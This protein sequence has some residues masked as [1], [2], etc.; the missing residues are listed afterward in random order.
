MLIDEFLYKIGFDVDSAKLQRVTVALNEIK[1]KAQNLNPILKN[2]QLIQGLDDFNNKVKTE[3]GEI[4][5]SLNEAANKATA[6]GEAIEKTAKS[7]DKATK[8]SKSLKQQFEDIKN[9]F[10]LVGIG[11]SVLGGLV[12][13]FLS[14]PLANIDKLALEKNKLF[15]ITSAEIDQAKEYHEKLKVTKNYFSSIATQVALKLLPSVNQGTAGF[16][17]FL[18]A[19][20]GLVVDGLT[21]VFE[22]VLKISQVF[23]NSFRA[24]NI[25]I[26][27]TI[28]WKNALIGLVGILAIVKRATILA[29]AF[30]PIG[31]LIGAITLLMLAY[32]D[33]MVYLD[34][35]KSFF[36]EL[37]DP[38][39]KGCETAVEWINYLKK[40]F[41]E[42]IE[43]FKN[44]NLLDTL[45]ETWDA[46]TKATK[47]FFGFGDAPKVAVQGVSA[48]GNKTIYNQG[49]TAQTTIN[50]NTNNENLANSVINNRQK[51]DL[52]FTN[53][54]FYG[55]D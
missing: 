41:N 29:F 4:K 51:S 23:M 11:A 38:F 31:L 52:A 10:F 46:T 35:G 20:K 40:T 53:S 27:S 14:V 32:D 28:G 21:K 30:S 36:G 13:K 33:L 22:W 1:A 9:K 39:I 15:D 26:T 54:N 47:M 7:I 37:W 50:I 18:K 6:S 25:M 48:Q 43:K 16:N 55:G 49:G 44:F 19:N 5:D 24:I 34:G 3:L 45:G 8:N 12:T 17:N 2:E 42:A